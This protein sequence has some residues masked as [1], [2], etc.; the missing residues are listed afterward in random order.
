MPKQFLVNIVLAS[1]LLFSQGGS[2]LI[3]ALCP[4]LQSE[5][6]SCE[7]QVSTPTMS[8]EQ[9]AH[10]AMGHG[11]M[12]HGDSSE[13][14]SPATTNLGKIAL[15]QLPEACSHCTIHSGTTPTGA[16]L[17]FADTVKRSFDLNI[18][19]AASPVEPVVATSVAVLS[20]RA[21]GPPGE[22]VPRHL[23]INIFR[24]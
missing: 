9:M 17:R 13:P 20:S 14:E 6:V 11:A 21:H 7:A 5:S 15:S 4:H 19:P 3:A 8:H 18:P 24:L 22:T 12:H 1:A 10:E 2:F 23:L 16:T